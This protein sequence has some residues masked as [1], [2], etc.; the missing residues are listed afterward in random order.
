MESSAYY[1]AKIEEYKGYQG[2][3][4]KAVSAFEGIDSVKTTSN[5]LEN[6]LIVGRRIDDNKLT[7]CLSKLQA[8]K[9]GLLAVIGECDQKIAENEALYQKALA[10]EK[11]QRR[12]A[13][14]ARKLANGGMTPMT[15]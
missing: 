9:G 11:E 8:A 3:V 4:G 7:E 15:K 1:K 14:E 6:L 2:E 12:L 10:Y 13:E 5:G